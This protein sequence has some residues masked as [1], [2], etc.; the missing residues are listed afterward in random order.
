[1]T[2]SVAD[3]IARRLAL[4]G[5]RWAFGVPGG[6]VL[7][8]IDALERAGIRFITAR[9]EAAAGFM[10]EGTW[11]ATGAPGILVATIGPG[12]ANA[13]N[14][15]ANAQQ[16]RTPLIVISGCV[17]PTDAQSYTHQVFDH[18]AVLAPL[19]KARFMVSVGAGAAIAEKA[20]AAATSHPPGPV[21]IDLPVAVAA[22][23]DKDAQAAARPMP[24]HS[25]PAGPALE[26]ARLMLQRSVRPLV[27]IGLEALTHNATSA[28]ADF[29]IQF[30][31]PV[32]TTYKAKGVID[33]DNPLCLGAAGLSPKADTIILPLVR[34]AD[35]VL[36]IGYDPIEMRAGWRHPFTSEQTVIE[37]AGWRAD[38]GMHRADHL[39][40]GDITESLAALASAVPPKR[41]WAA[42]ARNALGAAFLPSDAWGPG[43]IILAARAILPP[44][45]RA[46][47]DS[48]AHRILLSQIWRCPTPDG[49][50][51][52]SGLCTM[53]C[54]LPLAIGAA[55]AKVERD[56]PIVA[57]VGDGGLEMGL[58]E[59]ATLRDLG[60][61][62][63]IVVF[64][65]GA[66]A[67]IE[68]KQR[69]M[70]LPNA[71]VDLG[72]TD[73][74]AIATAFGGD[75]VTANNIPDFESAL[76]SALNTRDRFTLIACPI[77]RRSYDGLI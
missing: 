63:I 7:T 31:A 72:V 58:G 9:H 44:E 2:L 39:F 73:F 69:A 49:L 40:I 77:D 50:L 16:D 61:P 45:T 14:P 17:D 30:G 37:L 59:L 27:L 42:A 47:V 43:A 62:V 68:M 33:E 36:L 3:Q 66:Y 57:F 67:L 21:H 52:S 12:V 5:C 53:A 46:T 10:A 38:H 20:V 26:A 54:A 15:I 8:M 70:Q 55:V 34:E 11:H 75:G 13:I 1:M 22:S 24:A 23:S 60:L 76:R 71:G 51:Q 74:A 64:V 35:L 65:D 29:V 41:F 6:E 18:G 48:G 25:R 56:R 28:V 4:A 19:V 32:V